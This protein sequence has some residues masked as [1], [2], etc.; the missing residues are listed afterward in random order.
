MGRWFISTRCAP[1]V[2]SSLAVG[3]AD[4][5]PD[6]FP[7][8]AV[9]IQEVGTSAADEGAPRDGARSECDRIVAGRADAAEPTRFL[10]DGLE[11]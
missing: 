6:A 3:A 7:S 9:R 1:A 10:G 2:A 4:T 8:A 11:L 5:C